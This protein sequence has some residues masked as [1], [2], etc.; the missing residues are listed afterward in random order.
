M[1]IDLS[2]QTQALPAPFAFATT[3]TLEDISNEVNVHF[4]MEY[5]G[6][7][8]LSIEEVL[9]EGYSENDDYQWSGK[10]GN[11][12]CDV[13]A[14][15]DSLSYKAAP[16]AN[17]Y[18]HVLV[19]EQEKGFPTQDQELLIQEL[20]QAVFEASNKEA[21]LRIELINETNECLALAWIFAS[22]T[23]SINNQ[24]FDWTKG[25][26]IMNSLFSLD[27]ENSLSLK[28][29]QPL[30]ARFVGTSEWIKLQKSEATQIFQF[31]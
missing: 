17:S 6:R 8:E 23:F 13:M 9:S 19:N 3:I 4:E 28:K 5:L 15:I 25:K 16:S 1:K 11:N 29:P 10:L 18:L 20:I 27:M 22:R 30:T 14:E 2:Y 26:L 31:F 21:P 24:E 7:G 12:W